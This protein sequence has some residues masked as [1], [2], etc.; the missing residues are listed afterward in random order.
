MS[1][2]EMYAAH[3]HDDGRDDGVRQWSAHDVRAHPRN[4]DA[5]SVNIDLDA[6][7]NAIGDLMAALGLDPTTSEL[8]ETPRRAAAAM[9]ELLTARPFCLTTFPNEGYD[10]MVIVRD[11]PFHSMCAHHLLPFIGVAHVGYLP[12]DRI[13]GLSKLARVVEHFA[14]R[15]QTQE[16]LTSQIAAALDSALD[17][18]GVGV[19]MEATHLCMSLRGV[20]ASGA[21][22][23]TT[24]LTG[25]LRANDASR[26][27]FLG[28]V[29]SG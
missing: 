8:R 5:G 9:A 29:R 19:A 24:A 4:H 11:I 18:L 28:Q 2:V 7:T 27:E 1:A 15:P 12:A 17:P 20:H 21:K 25:L 26:A 13:V 6:A 14:R 10:E 22:T 16:R 23:V 3:R